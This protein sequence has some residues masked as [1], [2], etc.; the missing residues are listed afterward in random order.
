VVVPI[1]VADWSL[2]EL[3]KRVAEVRELYVRTLE[4]WP[5]PGAAK[6]I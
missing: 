5:D 4:D 6:E 1:H 3:D 2:D